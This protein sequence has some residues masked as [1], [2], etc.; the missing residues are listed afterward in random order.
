MRLTFRVVFLLITLVQSSS[1][2]F[3]TPRDT[4]EIILE[5]ARGNNITYSNVSIEQNYY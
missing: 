5:A 2:T 3:L 4:E 1:I